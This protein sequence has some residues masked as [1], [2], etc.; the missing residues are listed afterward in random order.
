MRRRR[1]K[2]VEEEASCLGEESRE[3]EGKSG[4]DRGGGRVGRTKEGW[5]GGRV[6]RGVLEWL[7]GP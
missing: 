7:E 1:R 4:I 2:R 3:G 6:E 5:E